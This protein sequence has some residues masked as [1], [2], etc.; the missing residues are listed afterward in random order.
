MLERQ[1]YALRDDEA[2]HDA[3][4]LPLSLSGEINAATRSLHTNLNRLITSRLPL[5]LPPHTTDSTLYATGLLH[6]AHIF[7]TF[8]S[9]WADLLRDYAPSNSPYMPAQPA[10][11]PEGATSPFSPLLS[12]LL[13]NP[14]DSP[15]LF[16]STLGAPTPPSPQLTTF[17]QSLRPRG[18][19]RS[20]RLK[21]DLEYLLGLHPTDLEVLLAK[22]PGNKVAQF[23]THIRKSVNEKPW[24]LV[25]Y[26]WCFYMAIFSGGR[27]IRGGLLRAPP[28]F[29]PSPATTTGLQEEADNKSPDLKNQ[30]LSFWHFPGPHDGED[31]KAEFKLR[32]AA[33]ETL[34]TPDERVDIIE[35]AKQIFKQCA[36]LVDELDDMIGTDFHF[37]PSNS[38]DAVPNDNSQHQT[39]KQQV[40]VDTC[41]LLEK[42]GL[43]DPNVMR[44]AQRHSTLTKPGSGL[45]SWIKK[46]EVSGTV[47]A[48]GCLA[49]VV[50][51]KLQ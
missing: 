11:D 25:S 28:S 35:E 22:Y 37:S 51:F 14:Y 39:E 44:R 42:S 3:P 43:I 15:S 47:L 31:I 36:E 46:P 5:G 16:T 17:L 27:W 7:L 4:G 6:F 32:L 24:T 49:C 1:E 33:A 20:G 29:W 9:L 41:P 19:I 30:G 45:R 48:V 34:F 40:Q 50:L 2:R 23:C 38:N 8:E 21:R 10:M 26:A 13:V 18:L 12:Y